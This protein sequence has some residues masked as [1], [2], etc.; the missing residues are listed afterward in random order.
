M[1]EQIVLAFDKELNTKI[2]LR[3]K[4]IDFNR[5]LTTLFVMLYP[6]TILMYMIGLNHIGVGENVY[7]SVG[8]MLL[9]IVSPLTDSMAYFVGSALGGPKLCPKISPKKTVSGA[10]GG[11]I[12]GMFGALI[13]YVLAFTGALDFMGVG[14]F[15]TKIDIVHFLLLGFLGAVSTQIGDLIASM[16]KRKCNIKDYGKLLPGHGGVMDRVDGMICSA[17]VYYVYFVFLCV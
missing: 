16:I 14:L 2:V 13:I 1:I 7:R 6:V 12:G 8:I 5:F 11:L 17:V 10:I 4:R 9:F 15:G 3:C